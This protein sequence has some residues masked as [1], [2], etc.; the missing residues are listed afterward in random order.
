MAVLLN[1]SLSFM[2]KLC[3]T[4]GGMD[5]RAEV[6]LMWGPIGL[7]VSTPLMPSSSPYPSHW[8]LRSQCF[9]VTGGL[10]LVLLLGGAV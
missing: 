4:A 5:G 10:M 7:A 6:V 2:F 3:M 1:M 8:Q 9:L